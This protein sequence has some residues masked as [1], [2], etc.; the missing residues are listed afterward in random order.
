[1]YTISLDRNPRTKWFP[2]FLILQDFLAR[3][4]GETGWIIKKKP[5]DVLTHLLSYILAKTEWRNP[6]CS[7]SYPI[8]KRIGFFTQNPPLWWRHTS[9]IWFSC[10]QVS[11]MMVFHRGKFSLSSP[12]QSKVNSPVLIGLSGLIFTQIITDF[13]LFHEIPSNVY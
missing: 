6:Y 13:N 7:S 9:S 12:I 4:K 5:E 1:M 2:R 3:K 8:F 11:F 10:Q